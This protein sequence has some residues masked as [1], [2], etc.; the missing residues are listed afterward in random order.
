MVK[1]SNTHGGCWLRSSKVTISYYNEII[2]NGVNRFKLFE[3]LS[4]T[5]DLQK[6]SFLSCL[7]LFILD[8]V[9]DILH[10]HMLPLLTNFGPFNLIN[11]MILGEIFYF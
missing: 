11:V 9:S 4:F 3:V 2:M 7:K 8:S 1:V 6:M 10:I 5:S